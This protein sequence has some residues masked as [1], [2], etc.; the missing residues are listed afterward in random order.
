MPKA[1]LIFA[2]LKGGAFMNITLLKFHIISYVSIL[3]IKC[4]RK[5]I[6]REYINVQKQVSFAMQKVLLLGLLNSCYVPYVETDPAPSFHKGPIFF[7]KK[8]FK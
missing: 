1:T 7:S 8:K 5:I 3:F 4:V 2:N 6:L